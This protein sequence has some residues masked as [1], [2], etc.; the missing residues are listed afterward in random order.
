MVEF[1]GIVES[2]QKVGGMAE[3]GQKV[4][5]DDMVEFGQKVGIGEKLKSDENVKCGEKV[6]FGQEGNFVK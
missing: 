6:E 1:G 2:T 5:D 4:E 3:F